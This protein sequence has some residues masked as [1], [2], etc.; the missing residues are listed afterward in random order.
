MMKTRFTAVL[1]SALLL[2]ACDHSDSTPAPDPR[3]QQEILSVK[4]LIYPYDRTVT[5][6]GI[7]DNRPDCIDPEWDTLTDDKGRELVRYRCDYTTAAAVNQINQQ[8]E[9]RYQRVLRDYTGILTKVT[10]WKPADMRTRTGANIEQTEKELGMIKTLS[11]YDWSP[12]RSEISTNNDSS[13]NLS[14]S[15]GKLWSRQ[16][17]KLTGEQKALV[18]QWNAVTEPLLY[19]QGSDIDRWF[20]DSSGVI[21]ALEKKL[22][23][24]KAVQAEEYLKGDNRRREDESALTRLLAEL[25]AAHAEA[26]DWRITHEL[27]WSVTGP[28]PV[29]MGGKFLVSDHTGQNELVPYSPV[30]RGPVRRGTEMLAD[31]YGDKT[32]TDFYRN[33]LA[34]GLYMYQVK[35]IKVPSVNT[36]SY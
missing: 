10:K 5:L 3:Q 32:G 30:T 16:P 7:L 18:E 1:L 9:A 11:G 20:E 29:F 34:F 2:T 27:Y 12:L 6:G 22:T 25:E 17:A 15:G 36:L 13:F 21:S 19:G 8:V 35:D 4:Q 28:D 33:M 14:L 23:D 31:I 26:K 24:L